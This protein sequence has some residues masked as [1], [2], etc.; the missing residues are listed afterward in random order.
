M[1][2]LITITLVVIMSSFGLN[3]Q[4]GHFAPVYGAQWNKGYTGEI[5][6]HVHKKIHKNGTYWVK[7]NTDGKQKHVFRVMKVEDQVIQMKFKEGQYAK[8]RNANYG[9]LR[10][11][12][13][14]WWEGRRTWVD[15]KDGYD[16][17]RNVRLSECGNLGDIRRP[18]VGSTDN[19]EPENG[20]VT[21]EDPS[22]NNNDPEDNNPDYVDEDPAGDNDPEDNNPNVNNNNNN[23]CPDN[24]HGI[25]LNPGNNYNPN[26]GN[27][28]VTNTTTSDVF[29]S[30]LL[31]PCLKR[32]RDTYGNAYDREILD[33][34]DGGKKSIIKKIENERVRNQL[35]SCLK[36]KKVSILKVATYV[37]VAAA[38]LYGAYRLGK[39]VIE[40]PDNIT[41]PQ[42][43]IEEEVEPIAPWTD[44][45]GPIEEGG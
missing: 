4:N 25:M 31:T 7:T 12:D 2:N 18:H 13:K 20:T 42:P 23:N 10:Y 22:D 36:I 11:A 35:M 45:E 33:Y 37:V 30:Y 28:N 5:S 38:A 32:F 44:Y 6:R 39:F 17:I 43:P 40:L 26:L 29:P 41:P 19:E 21:D 14:V 15:E 27:D 24:G 9:D 34:L 16:H 8:G 1:K 3:A